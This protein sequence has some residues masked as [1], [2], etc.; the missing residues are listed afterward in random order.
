VSRPRSVISPTQAYSLMC[1][2]GVAAG[3]AETV[4]LVAL[5]FNLLRPLGLTKTAF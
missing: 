2:H 5:W 4:A 3:A 1:A